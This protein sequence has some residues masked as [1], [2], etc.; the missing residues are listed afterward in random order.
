MTDSGGTIMTESEIRKLL[1][2]QRTFFS[3]GKTLPVFFRQ[4][5]RYL[6]LNNR[7]ISAKEIPKPDSGKMQT[8]S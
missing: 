8:G 4:I 7:K 2:R 3:T 5:A 1:E 6:P